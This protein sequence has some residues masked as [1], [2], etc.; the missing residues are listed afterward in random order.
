MARA[1]IVSR[2]LESGEAE[3][4]V[5]RRRIDGIADACGAEGEEARAKEVL[6]HFVGC[7]L[8]TRNDGTGQAAL[9]LVA[10]EQ[11]S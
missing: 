8:G 4:E 9:R 5:K 11:D 2:R 6:M 7:K 3:V 10:V 1:K